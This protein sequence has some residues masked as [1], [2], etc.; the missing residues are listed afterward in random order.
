M[1][2]KSR[3]VKQPIMSGMYLTEPAL[4]VV[5][6]VWMIVGDLGSCSSCLLVFGG[7]ATGNSR[8]RVLSR[9][10]EQQSSRARLSVYDLQQHKLYAATGSSGSQAAERKIHIFPPGPAPLVRELLQSYAP[11]NFS[12]WSRSCYGIPV[13]AASIFDRLRVL[14]SSRPPPSTPISIRETAPAVKLEN[15][16]LGQLPLAHSTEYELSQT[17]KT[18]N[19]WPVCQNRHQMENSCPNTVTGE[20][21]PRGQKRVR[22]VTS[23]ERQQE[24]VDAGRKGQEE[25]GAWAR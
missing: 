4:Q 13:N 9:A 19:I 12:H 21:T 17:V 25:G 5:C 11:P 10:T 15:L 23:E 24:S 7:E 1:S 20:I 14:G 18:G 3:D 22:K 6:L 2:R 16:P 8:S